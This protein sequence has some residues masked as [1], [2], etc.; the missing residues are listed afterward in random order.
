MTHENLNLLSYMSDIG[1]RA[2]SQ[3]ALTPLLVFLTLSVKV[4]RAGHNPTG[5]SL[6]KNGFLLA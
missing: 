6:K 3:A 1:Q 4:M 2:A 5:L